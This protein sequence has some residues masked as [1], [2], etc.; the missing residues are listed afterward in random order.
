MSVPITNPE[1]I[2]AIAK[3]MAEMI[4]SV[5]TDERGLLLAKCGEHLRMNAEGFTSRCMR[6][7]AKLYDSDP[8]DPV[9]SFP[10]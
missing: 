5:D 9:R 6:L 3:V 8:R 4:R 1:E 2:D 10:V 7:A